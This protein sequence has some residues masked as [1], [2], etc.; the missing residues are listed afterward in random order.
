MIFCDTFFS[1]HSPL[2]VKLGWAFCRPGWTSTKTSADSQLPAHPFIA[3]CY[4]RVTDPDVKCLDKTTQHNNYISSTALSPIPEEQRGLQFFMRPGMQ[5]KPK[6]S[7]LHCTVQ[8][9]PLKCRNSNKEVYSLKNNVPTCF[10]AA[11]DKLSNNA[12]YWWRTPLL[13]P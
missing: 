6:R 11:V 12:P 9:L 4:I 1:I 5:K 3:S 2:H 10:T 8:S 13:C 7:F